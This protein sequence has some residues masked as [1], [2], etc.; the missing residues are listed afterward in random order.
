MIFLKRTARN[1]VWL[2]K[3]NTTIERME[4]VRKPAGATDSKKTA[5]GLKKLLRI[6]RSSAKHWVG[7]GFPVRSVLNYS[8][9]GPELTPFLLLD[10]A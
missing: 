8:D 5:N 10:Y 4:G 2:M 6:H 3:E 9:H 1:Y 7:N